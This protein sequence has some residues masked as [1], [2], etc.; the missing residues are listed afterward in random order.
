MRAALAAVAAASA[1]VGFVLWSGAGN[2]VYTSHFDGVMG[3]SL[4][5]SVQSRTAAAG[6]QAEQAIL[7]EITRESGILSGYDPASEFSRWVRSPAVPTRV[8]PELFDVL[9]A[10]DDWRTRTAGALDPAAETLTRVW[11]HAAG[12]NRV[13]TG[14]ELQSALG[15]LRQRHWILD[16]EA[17]TATHASHVPLMLNSF[18]KSPIPSSSRPPASTAATS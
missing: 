8:S 2:G 11:K 7:D 1:L 14:A 18:T 12:E 16:R 10:F 17:S 13:P 5:I 6:W 4:E 3:T 15:D 9:S